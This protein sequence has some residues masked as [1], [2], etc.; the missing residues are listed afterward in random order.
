ML[1]WRAEKDLLEMCKE[2]GWYFLDVAS[3]MYDDAG[4][5][6]DSYC[7]DLSSMGMHFTNEGCDA[8]VNYLKTHAINAEAFPVV[9]VPEAVG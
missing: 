1:N 9:E 6:K 7:S 2:N 5:L 8:W 4:Y 3:V